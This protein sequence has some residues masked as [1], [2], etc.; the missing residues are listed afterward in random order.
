MCPLRS[1]N[2]PRHRRKLSAFVIG[3][4]YCCRQSLRLVGDASSSIRIHSGGGGC[5]LFVVGHWLLLVTVIVRCLLLF[6]LFAPAY[7]NTSYPAQN[8]VHHMMC[9]DGK[10]GVLINLRQPCFT[11]LYQFI[12]RRRLPR[13][14][15]SEL[16]PL[17]P[18][19]CVSCRRP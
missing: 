2:G 8:E 10:D 7:I 18:R 5:W 3:F 14:F 16:F 9:S 11:M 19:C 6:L 13:F 15:V 4:N 12:Y 17:M 1:R